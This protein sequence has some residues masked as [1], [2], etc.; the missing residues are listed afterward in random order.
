MLKG[1]V[2]I[3]CFGDFVFLLFIDEGVVLV[4]C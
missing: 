1:K 4:D 2:V 3:L